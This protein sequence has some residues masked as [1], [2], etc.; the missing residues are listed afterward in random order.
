MRRTSLVLLLALAPS[1]QATDTRY[2][3]VV[4][5]GSICCGIDHNAEARVKDAIARHEQQT[6]QKIPQLRRYWGKEGEIN[7][8][9]SPKTATAALEASLRRA[10][11]GATATTVHRNAPCDGR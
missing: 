2:P 9:L 5:F 7:L 4:S 10:T 11:E 8:C 6:G 1:A 3:L